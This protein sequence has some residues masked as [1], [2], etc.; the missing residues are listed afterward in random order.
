M[1]QFIIKKASG[2][3]PILKIP[4]FRPSQTILY[5]K[6]LLIRTYNGFFQLIKPFQNVL[7]GKDILSLHPLLHISHVSYR[8][9]FY[10]WPGFNL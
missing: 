7:F 9:K 10:K 1:N 6:Y 2:R 4:I 8:A 5:E 3:Y